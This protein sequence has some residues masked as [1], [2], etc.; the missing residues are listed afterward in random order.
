M[1]NVNKYIMSKI[2]TCTDGRKLVIF[3]PMTQYDPQKLH[4]EILRA[5]TRVYRAGNP[6]P[7]QKLAVPDIA[8]EIFVKREDLSPINAYKW[9]GAYNCTAHLVETRGVKTVVAASAGNHAQGVAL[10]ARMMGIHAKIFMPLSTPQMKQKAVKLH[11]GN[12]VEI[13]LIGDTY[14]QASDA[15]KK[16]VAEH[17]L[18]YV[19][20]FDDL[21]TIAGQATIADEAM[22]SGEGPFDYVFL[23]IGGGGM[24]GGVAAWIKAHHP[25][26]KVIGVEGIGQASMA[27]SLKRGEP[28]TLHEVDTF[29]DGTAVKRPGDLTFQICK[30]YLDDMVLVT[31]EEVSAGI[32]QFWDSKRVIPEPAGA[33]GLAGLQKYAKDHNADLTGK[34][35]LIVLC[36]ANMDFG[37]LALISS[38][39]AIGAHRRRYLRFHLNEQKGSLLDLLDNI[40][41]DVNVSEFQYGKISETDGYPVIAFEATPEKMDELRTELEKSNIHFEDITDDPDIRF[42]VINYN[43]ALFQYPLFMQVQFPERRG[44]LREFMRQV[45]GIANLCYFNYTYTGETIGR[46]LMCFEF[47]NTEN[48][49][50]MDEVIANSP[51]ECRHIPDEV[52]KRMLALD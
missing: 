40:F 25:T 38:Q 1:K 42:R 26:T 7:L 44:A 9:R 30:T 49:T 32:Q 45:S 20:P 28:V 31:N 13:M 48:R 16:Y 46:A 36:G 23:Q 4:A 35:I 17:D 52:A 50:K 19:H 18:P 41:S 11:G 24:A 15:A 37:K 43:P 10:A 34:K 39:S 14:D 33:M 5:R 21:Y 22:L 3:L 2:H 47:T 6:T 29:C 8:A 12:N 27:A 51:V